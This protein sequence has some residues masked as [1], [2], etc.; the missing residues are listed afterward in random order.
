[1]TTTGT[2]QAVATD[3]ELL[4]AWSDGDAAAG[5]ALFGR[6]FDTLLRFFFNKADEDAVEDLIQRTMLAC[7][8]SR[9]RFRRDASFRTWLFVI[10]RNELLQLY[11]RRR[12]SVDVDF[13]IASIA[14]LA[15]SPS[16]AVIK[17]EDHVLLLQALRQLP[18][19]QQLLLELHYWQGLPAN[20]LAVVF[21]VDPT[22]IRTRLHRA[23]ARL[24][25]L[26]EQLASDPA[27]RERVVH[28]LQTWAR[29][30]H[31]ELAAAHERG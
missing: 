22:T 29:E 20:E 24:K 26:V 1:M 27:R 14:D 17:N 15:T 4:E 30:I 25:D 10:A 5:N 16:A 8:R 19:D 3:G 31:A 18:T 7:L 9:D 23:R 28:G 2:L 11:R 6:Y 21:G 12:P 13:S